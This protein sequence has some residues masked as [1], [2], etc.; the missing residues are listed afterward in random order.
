MIFDH[1]HGVDDK[2]GPAMSHGTEGSPSEEADESERDELRELGLAPA[3]I[4]KAESG[5]D[6]EGPTEN[7][8]NSD[9]NIGQGSSVHEHNGSHLQQTQDKG[10]HSKML[11][12][13]DDNHPGKELDLGGRVR[14]A[15]RSHGSDDK[16]QHPGQLKGMPN[17]NIKK[18]SSSQY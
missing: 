9:N 7:K 5:N 3:V 17:K 13:H 16:G 11:M 15:M 8:G 14:A 1:S 12:G 18:G 6:L 10:I 2:H 4:D